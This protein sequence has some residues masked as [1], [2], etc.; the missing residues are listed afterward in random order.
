MNNADIHLSALFIITSGNP[1][2][3][4][5]EIF[6]RTILGDLCVNL[7]ALCGFVVLTTKVMRDV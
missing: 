1:D 6:Y 2:I 7:R 5:P 3:S 4:F